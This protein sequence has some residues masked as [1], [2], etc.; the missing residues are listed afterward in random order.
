[1]GFIS[2]YSLSQGACM[3]NYKHYPVEYMSLF[4]EKTK[5]H[6]RLLYCSNFAAAQWAIWSLL[7][8]CI[9]WDRQ[10]LI[11]WG[12]SHVRLLCVSEVV[13]LC[14][15]AKLTP[16]RYVGSSTYLPVSVMP[17]WPA[18]PPPSTLHTVHNFRQ[19]SRNPLKGAFK[20]SSIHTWWILPGNSPPKEA[21]PPPSGY[22]LKNDVLPTM[23]PVIICWKPPVHLP[24]LY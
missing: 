7:N 20:R 8:F 24:C 17:Y 23:F 13:A 18:E 16:G 3:S 5:Q 4:S 6:K 11:V 22:D 12:R 21:L 14:P 19:N 1:M 2:Y 9:L 10:A 15:I